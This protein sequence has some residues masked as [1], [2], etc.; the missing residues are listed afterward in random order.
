MITSGSRKQ[1]GDSQ[2]PNWRFQ[3]GRTQTNDVT[4]ATSVIVC[5]FDQILTELPSASAVLHVL[6]SMF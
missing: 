6:I 4:D 5:D 3:N 1:D 2:N